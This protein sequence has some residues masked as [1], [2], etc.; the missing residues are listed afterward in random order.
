M[1]ENKEYA[2]IGNELV[3]ADSDIALNW[4]M[5]EYDYDDFEEVDRVEG[6]DRRWSR[7][8][9]VV[10]KHRETGKL[11]ELAYEHGLTENQESDCYDTKFPE[12]TQVKKERTI[13]TYSYEK[14][15]TK[16]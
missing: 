13:I 4:C 1:E 16:S 9:T 14:V 3:L 12:V 11:F 10:L 2:I 5:E 6:E 8:V 15:V 7:T